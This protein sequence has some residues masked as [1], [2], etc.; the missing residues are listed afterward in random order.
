[1]TLETLPIDPLLDSI[2]QTMREN[3]CAVLTATPGAGKTTR[4]PPRLLEV[5]GGKI[6]ILQPRR[7]AAVAAATRIAS[8]RNLTLGREV[9]YQ[10]RFESKVSAETRLVFMTDALLLRRMTEDP[11]LKEFDMIVLDE[12]HERNLNQDILLGCLKELRELGRDIKIL[13]MSATLNL[14]R[15]RRFLPEAAVIDVPGKVFPL[16]IH[17]LEENLKL[18][19]DFEFYDR[20]G[21]AVLDFLQ[22]SGG[23]VLV[24]LPGVGEISRLQDWLIE[25]GVREEILPL[26]GSLPL[27]EQQKILKPHGARRVVLAT[28]VAEASLTVPGVDRVI[29][30]GLSKVTEM[31]RQSGFSRL[32]L[33]RIARFNADQRAGRAARQGPGK[34]MRLWSLHEEATQPDELP[35]E[36]QRVDLSQSLLFLSHLGVSDF[37]GFSW[38]DAPPAANLSLA[39][40]GLKQLG[41]IDADQRLTTFGRELMRFPLPPRW[42]ALLLR[43]ENRGEIRLGA[44]AA[45]LMQDRDILR[46]RRE[47]HAY[48]ECDLT[49]RLSLIDDFQTGRTPPEIQKRAAQTVVEAAHQLEG[50]CRPGAKVSAD[51]NALRNLLIS[52]QSDR[53]CRRR[54]GTDRGLMVGG[55]GVRLEKESQVRT[56]EF[57]IALNGIDLPGQNETV[58]SMACGLTKEFVLES[59]RDRIQVV[60]DVHFDEDRGQL[61]AR[62]FR[63]FMDL[64]LDEPTLSPL[65]ADRLGDHLAEIVKARWNQVV[66]KSEALRDWM[67]RWKFAVKHEP[68]FAEELDAEAVGRICEMAAFGK[69]SLEEVIAMDLVGLVETQL[70][71]EAVKFLH[72]E[73]PPKFQAP[74]GVSHPIRFEGESG[75]FVEVRLQEIFGLLSTPKLAGG[76]VP[77]TF[78]LLGPNYRP[79][80]VTSDLAGFWKGAY[81][82]V[83]KEL[84]ARYPKHSW[85]EDPLTARPEAKGRRR[86]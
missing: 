85:P 27:A 69:T 22:S 36:V 20:T 52:T 1:M 86:S 68:R 63:K 30:T 35:P 78:R 54:K 4:L 58:I 18:R 73:V 15:L 49:Y 67:A 28:N 80:Q 50:L 65:G 19:T 72:Q 14:S 55:R 44:L 56:S 48:T 24:F 8:E 46:E 45:A 74:S 16:E 38:L 70:S 64:T 83:R 41:A 82:E 60:E 3:W 29:D 5:V 77:L 2:V 11:E 23:D 81:N 57:F 7:V 25:R 71:K 17:H 34:C 9:G 10:V 31:D 84:R 12:F 37:S 21:R 43:A 40:R 62:R 13:I 42:G 59:L 47:I 76:R 32:S 75:V 26:H 33:T 39:V 61:Y 53:L 6:A 79:V 51:K 66:E